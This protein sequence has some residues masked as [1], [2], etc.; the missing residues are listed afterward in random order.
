M[1]DLRLP[2]CIPSSLI[3]ALAGTIISSLVHFN[4]F[5]PSLQRSPAGIP[6]S[7][8]GLKDLSEMK[9]CVTPLLKIP[10]CLPKG[11]ALQVKALSNLVL[12]YLS[13]FKCIT[14]SVILSQVSHTLFPRETAHAV[15]SSWST[16]SSSSWLFVLQVSASSW[17]SALLNHFSVF[18]CQVYVWDE[19]L[20]KVQSTAPHPGTYR[21][22]CSSPA[23]TGLWAAQDNRLHGADHHCIT[24]SKYRKPS[25]KIRRME[26]SG[27]CST[28]YDGTTFVQI[29]HSGKEFCLYLISTYLGRISQSSFL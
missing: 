3:L 18:L 20:A 29:Y 8:H 15:P 5:P 2:F 12:A 10:S 21:Q 1:S 26:E 6:S 22:W 27:Q 14:S 17:F 4:S 23:C 11:L 19:H 9:I 25:L 28:W 24:S 13:R 16:L 7:F